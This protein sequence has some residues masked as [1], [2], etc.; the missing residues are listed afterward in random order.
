MPDRDKST[1]SIEVR[2]PIPLPIALIQHQLQQVA[3]GWPACKLTPDKLRDPLSGKVRNT[4]RVAIWFAIERA[5]R[6]LTSYP[7]ERL[8]WGSWV[9]ESYPEE[10][11]RDIRTLGATINTGERDG[12]RRTSDRA[13]LIDSR[14]REARLG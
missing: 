5:R 6:D 3:Y 13:H 4:R 9:P 8:I 10:L 11:P 1:P 2:D 7:V 12:P 14:P